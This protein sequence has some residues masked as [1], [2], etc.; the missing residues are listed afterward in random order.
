MQ[1][2]WKTDLLSCSLNMVTFA[3]AWCD[4]PAGDQSL[5]VNQELVLG[6]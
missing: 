5:M 6:S 3:A 4:D 2:F 1:V